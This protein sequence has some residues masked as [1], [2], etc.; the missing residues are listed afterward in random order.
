MHP[1]TAHQADLVYFAYKRM[2][3]SDNFSFANNWLLNY[4]WFAPVS[5]A[6]VS[7]FHCTKLVAPSMN[8]AELLCKQYK[9]GN[10]P[11]IYRYEGR[12]NSVM[13][14]LFEL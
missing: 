7:P 8:S 9:N 11:E 3:F 4:M 14:L 2:V 13:Y 10:K 1:L 5:S 12:L 6:N